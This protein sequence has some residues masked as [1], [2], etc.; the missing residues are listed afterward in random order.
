MK[1][2]FLFVLISA[3]L[4]IAQTNSVDSSSAVSLQDSVCISDLV[5]QQIK[6]AME[7]QSIQTEPIINVAAQAE[8]KQ[9]VN[10]EIPSFLSSR[11]LHVKIFLAG[12]I[13]ILL[14]FSFRRTLLVLKKKSKLALKN[15]IA[16]LREEKVVTK[17]NPKLEDARKKLRNSKSIFDASEKHISKVAKELNIAKGE[18]L[19]ASRLKLFEIGK[20]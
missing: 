4:L 6:Y 7:K 14:A 8:I 16:M 2:L 12:S 1:F 5:Q 9:P 18:L 17:T 15:K 19:L 11:P 20:M 13:V 3:S 10:K